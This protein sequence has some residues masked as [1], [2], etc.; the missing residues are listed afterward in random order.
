MRVFLLLK[1]ENEIELQ[2]YQW[3]HLNEHDQ[4]EK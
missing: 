4:P 1:F 3:R 2:T